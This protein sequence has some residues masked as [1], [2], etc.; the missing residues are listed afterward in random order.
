[1]TLT[2]ATGTARASL[3]SMNDAFYGVGSIVRDGNTGFDWL[4]LKKSTNFSVN[5]ILGGGGA[6]LAQAFQ[7]A[8]LGQVEAMY[9]SG[10]WD[11]VDDTA[12]AGNPAHKAFV[13]SMQSLFGVTGTEFGTGNPFN[14]GWA[15]TSIPNRVSRPF[16]VLSANAG[17]V[18]C[19]TLGFNTFTAPVNNFASCRMDYDQKFDYI[20]AYLVRNPTAQA[21]VPEPATLILLSSGL[22]AVG[23]RRR[24]GKKQA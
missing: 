8:T 15:L 16:N 14:E 22:A 12:I 5:D 24:R 17:R 20:G 18:A 1:M 3:I 21:T 10:G 23:C 9:T 6:F 13:L 4:N 7:L 2:L 19:T 11:G